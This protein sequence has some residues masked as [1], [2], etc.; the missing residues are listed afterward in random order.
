MKRWK[1]PLI[2]MKVLKQED[3]HNDDFAVVNGKV[4]LKKS[5]RKYLVN[6]NNENRPWNNNQ[7]T[8][9]R[10]VTITD[11]GFGMIHLDFQRT[12]HNNNQHI[13][14]ELPANCPTPMDLIE[15]QLHDGNTIWIDQGRRVIYSSIPKNNTNRYIVNL[16]GF[17]NL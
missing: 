8:G 11:S 2:Y 15:E 7:N 3:L 9:L 4:H 1:I 12:T 5:I 14:G 16:T 6:F 17:F 13:V 10:T